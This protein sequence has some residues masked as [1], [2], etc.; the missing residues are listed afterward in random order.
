MLRQAT[1][2][3]L[4]APCLAVAQANLPPLDATIEQSINRVNNHPAVVKAME[5]IKGSG[6]RMLEE[7]VRINEIPAP[8]FK[9]Q[10]RAEYYLKKIREAGLTDAVIDKEG[11][12]IGVRRG[13][14]KGKGPKLVV[15]AHLDTVFPEGTNVKVREKDGRFYAPGISDD[16][17]GLAT[18]LTAIEQLQKSGVRTIGDIYFV[19]TVGEEELGD[20]RGVKALFLDHRDIDAFISLD[21]VGLGRIVN[22]ATGSHRFNVSFKG[23]GGHSFSAFGLPSAI[24]AMG[25][26]VAKIGDLVPPVTPKT[27]FT[28]GTVRGGTSVNAISGDAAIGID[29]RSNSHAELVK[30]VDKV[31]A[32]IHEAVADENKRWN[33]TAQI[34]VDIKQVGDRPAGATPVDAR[35]VHAA[36]AAMKAVGAEARSMEASS[37]DSNLPISLGVPA[38]TLSS[39]GQGGS[40]HSLNEWYSPVNNTLG[41]QNIVLLSLALVGVEGVT[42]PVL[43]K[44]FAR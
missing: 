18:L 27:T 29:V 1:L 19:G 32:A 7:Q 24:H 44:R 5:S 26:A 34:T 21:G 15:S 13:S 43:E 39:S 41:V 23:P 3:L 14:G 9:E 4:I 17:A 28:V 2:V 10:A 16:A 8:P 12:V 33:S 20:L 11:N 40:S 6:I 38:I 30:F 42:E 36:R 22:A 25:R 35:I 31:M 37:T